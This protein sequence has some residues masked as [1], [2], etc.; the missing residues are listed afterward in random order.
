MYE[1]C[2]RLQSDYIVPLSDLLR[3]GAATRGYHKQL[4]DARFVG[5]S[6]AILPY[7]NRGS[8][9]DSKAGKLFTE[10]SRAHPG[11]LQLLVRAHLGKVS[12]PSL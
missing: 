1:V 10:I 5:R 11:D 7:D 6:R 2:N 12:L 8:R 4:S 9:P 3:I